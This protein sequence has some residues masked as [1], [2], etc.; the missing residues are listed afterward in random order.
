MAK[1]RS[2]VSKQRHALL[3]IK[4]DMME[5]LLAQHRKEKKDLQAK[6][7]QKKKNT[8]KKTRK[9]VNDD[10]E[11][12]ERELAEKQQ[13]EI[14]AL[15]PQD[16]TQLTEYVEN[17]AVHESD[18]AVHGEANSELKNVTHDNSDS[19][20]TEPPTKKPNRQ[21]ARLARRAAEQEA[22]A[23]AAAEEAKNLPDRR[24]QELSAM[25]EQM[26]KLGLVETMIRPD[27]HCLF[28]ACARSIP[29]DLLVSES[30]EVKKQPYHNVRH[31]AANFMTKHPDDFEA[32]MEEPLDSYVKK[33]RDTAEW[34]GQL[35]LQAIARSYDVDIN[36]LQADGRV[37]MITSGS[38]GKQG[39]ESIWLA[40]YKHSFGLGEHYNALKKM[41][42]S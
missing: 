1:R 6:I 25:K 5:E 29:E 8:T 39:S 19:T 34:G 20:T 7:T 11:R 37:E 17:L 23:A 32:F 28:S 38:D 42:N 36:V 40:Y 22:Q 16:Q 21:K 12:L 2:S 3:R 26:K 10:C 15:E 35:E 41:D 31:A 27:G 33:I 9:G 14:Q 4:Y 24:E 13:A 18:G 30:G